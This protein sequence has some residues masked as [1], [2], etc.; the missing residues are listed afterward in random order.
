MAF[1]MRY[2]IKIYGHEKGLSNKNVFS[3]FLKFSVV[4]IPAAS[5]PMY[6]AV[7][8]WRS[9]IAG[10]LEAASDTVCCL[11]SRQLLHWLFFGMASKLSL[12]PIISFL[13]VGFQLCSPCI[14]V[15]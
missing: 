15:V 13:T 14:A 5:D 6:M 9:C 10:R 12:F 11:M 2:I 8:C 3:R 4:V 1:S 7:H